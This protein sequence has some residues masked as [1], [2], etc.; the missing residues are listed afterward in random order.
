MIFQEQFSTKK[1]N[2]A[3]KNVFEYLVRFWELG[4]V[5]NFSGTPSIKQSIDIYQ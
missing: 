5:E 2:P 1:L 4:W 3:K